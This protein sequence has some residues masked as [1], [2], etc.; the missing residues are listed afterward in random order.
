MLTYAAVI[1]SFLGGIHWGLWP[2][3]SNACAPWLVDLGV[4]LPS[5]LAWA[6][7]L[8]NSAWGLLLMAASLILC[9]VVDAQIY[10]PL[11]LGSLAD[12]ARH[13]DLCG[14][15]VLPGGCSSFLGLASA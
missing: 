6:G 7:L 2:C 8:L 1:V 14:G 5:L 15:R 9:Y 4:C 13:A 3:G 10:R 12:L 11:Q